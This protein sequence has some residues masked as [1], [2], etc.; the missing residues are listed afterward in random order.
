MEIPSQ[1]RLV[2]IFL[3]GLCSKELHSAVYTKH[4]MY[5]DQC[6]YEAIEYDDNCSKGTAGIGSQ[7]NESTTKI[8]SQ[9]DDI[10]RGVTTRMQ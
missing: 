9:L 10:I 8:S 7:T 2:S 6:I 4:F 1:E 3:E 5:L